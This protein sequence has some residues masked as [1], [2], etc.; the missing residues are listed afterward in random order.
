MS[1]ASRVTYTGDAVTTTYNVPMPY[2]SKAH[3]NIY[4]NQTLQLDPMNYS[5]TGPST[6]EFTS[7]PAINDAIEIVRNTSPSAILVD[8]TDGSVLRADDL[9]TAY[10]HNYYL[11]QEYS[12][13]YNNA[14]NNILIQL[15][16]DT[17]IVETET[18]AIIDA[19]VQE[20]LADAAAATLQTRVSDIDANAEAIITLGEGLQTQINTLAAGVAANVYIQADEPVPGVGGIPDPILEG[21]RWYDSDDNNKPYIYQ[22]SAWVSIE[23]PRIGVASAGVTTLTAQMGQVVSAIVEEQFVRANETETLGQRLSLIGSESGDRQAFIVDLDTTKVSDSESLADRFTALSAADGTNA[24][25]II[26]EQTARISGDD[27]LSSSITSL[28]ATVGGNTSNITTNAVAIASAEG[29]ITTLYAKYGVTLNV[30]GYITGFAQNNDGTTG[31]F[32]VL[33]DKFAVVDPSGDPGEPEYVPFSISGGKITLTGDVTVNGSL[34]V[35]GTV[36]GG[37]IVAGG[38]GA[39]Q[40]GTNAITTDKI[41]AN[42]ITAAKI[43]ASQ[44]TA[45]HIGAATVQALGIT[46][47]SLSVD[48]TL[49]MG[50]SGKMISTGTGFES[51]TGFFLG[52]DV[53]AYKF[54]VGNSATGNYMSWDGTDLTVSGIINVGTYTPT[55]DVIVSANTE[56]VTTGEWSGSAVWQTKKTFTSDKDGTFRLKFD[57]KKSTNVTSSPYTNAQCRITRNSSVVAYK[58]ITGTA[59]ASQS[60]DIAVSAGDVIDIDLAKGTYWNTEPWTIHA[61]VKNATFNG[62]VSFTGNPTVNLD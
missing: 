44:I 12:D 48:G 53:S 59:Y 1:F 13:S 46:T 19:L 35:N 54:Y 4:V 45:T 33:A 11:S 62:A 18:T 27:A 37:A 5:W 60:Q 25:D 36:A 3:V 23:D 30:N 22:S 8:F 17:G 43:A 55:D 15:A 31:T 2:I 56:R 24:A 40:I 10:L 61:Y 47:G 6:I 42:A 28:T 29:D 38:I 51:G 21:S 7:A 52:Y 57:I 58:T 34:L 16:T 20:M 49:T 9:D 50:T 41:N 32:V 39:T 26:T 14:I